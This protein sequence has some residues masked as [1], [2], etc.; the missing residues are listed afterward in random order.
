[1]A[2]T[3]QLSCGQCGSTFHTAGV[4]PGHLQSV[5][6]QC[7]YSGLKKRTYSAKAIESFRALEM[8]ADYSKEKILELY[9]N[10]APY[11]GNIIGIE[12][13]ARK[14]FDKPAKD[15][16]LGEASCLQVSHRVL[17]DLTRGI[18][19]KKY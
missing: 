11:G 2:L 14:Y 18:I 9:L 8:E 7:V 10:L 16:T 1:M 19:L 4:F 3:R 17:Q 13:A 6:S 12:A 15:L 5:C